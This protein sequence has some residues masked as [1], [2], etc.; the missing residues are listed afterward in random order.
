MLVGAGRQAQ[1]KCKKPLHQKQSKVFVSM[2]EP[3]SYQMN[4]SKISL[5]VIYII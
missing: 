1:V 3:C 2:S 4:M 5:D